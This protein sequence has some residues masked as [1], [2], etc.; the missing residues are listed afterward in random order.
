MDKFVLNLI[1]RPEMVPEYAEKV[2]GQGKTE[3]IGR[4]ALLTESLDI[5]KTQQ[6][7]AK[8]LKVKQSTVNDKIKRIRE[9]V[10]NSS[11]KGAKKF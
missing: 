7:I 1:Y 4:K 8:C 6:E 11:I 5:F 2:T 10:K 3:D 9:K